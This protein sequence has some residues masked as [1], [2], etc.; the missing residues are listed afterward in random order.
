MELDELKEKWRESNK[1]NVIP[2]RGIKSIL[3]RRDRGPIASLKRNFRRQIV[4]LVIVFFLFLHQFRNRE[5]YNNIFFLWYVVVG[6]CMIIVFYLNLRIVKKLE[7]TDDTV[8][9]HLSSQ[10]ILLQKRMRWQRI[11]ARIAIIAL[12]I[13]LEIV[14]FF[15]NESMIQKWHAVSPLIRIAAYIALLSFQ[16]FVGKFRSKR[17]YGQHIERLKKALEDME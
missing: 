3:R 13:L 4:L 11:S 12:I 6:L 9:A 2:K 16:H 10:I 5:L 1:A 8:V 17:R 15:S 14:P 7:N